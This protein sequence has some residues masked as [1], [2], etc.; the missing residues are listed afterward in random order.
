MV[1]IKNKHRLKQKEIRQLLEEIHESLDPSFTLSCASVETGRIDQYE[2]IF[3][4]SIPCFFKVDDQLF[5]T[6]KA[7]KHL[8]GINHQVIVDM[9]A[10]KFVTSGADVMAPGIVA[11]DRN[12]VVDDVVWICDETHKKPLAVGKAVM[13]GEEMVA[14]K[15]GKAARIFHFIGDPLWKMMAAL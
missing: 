13:D 4:D 14:S 1:K 8:K 2:L 11:A 5:Y 9:G 10:V 7:V 3:L 6:L 15:K 12:I